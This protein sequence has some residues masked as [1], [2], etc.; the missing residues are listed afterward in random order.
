MWRKDYAVETMKRDKECED[1]GQ[2]RGETGGGREGRDKGREGLRSKVGVEVYRW[3]SSLRGRCH[4]LPTN[5]PL[6]ANSLSRSIF[7][8]PSR[9]GAGRGREASAGKR[10]RM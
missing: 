9:G 2:G 5:T 4:Y 10:G 8:S 3:G 6:K 1:E 7:P